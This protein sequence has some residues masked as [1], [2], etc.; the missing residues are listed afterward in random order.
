M[1]QFPV[2]QTAGIAARWGC[3]SCCANLDPETL[4]DAGYPPGRG[5]YFMQCAHCKTYTWF[6]LI[7]QSDKQS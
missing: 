3:H 7:K 5:Q 4:R 2:Y 6:D 1:S